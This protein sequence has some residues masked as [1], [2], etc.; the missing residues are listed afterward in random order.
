M[1]DEFNEARTRL[2]TRLEHFGFADLEL[3]R[4]LLNQATIV[5]STAKHEFFGVAVV[6]AMAAGAAPVLP[7]DLSYPE[8]IPSHVHTFTLYDDDSGLDELLTRFVSDRQL[9]EQV[10]TEVQASVERCSW[11]VVAPT[12]D[13]RLS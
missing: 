6:E 2:A 10:T 3:Y 7:N 9:V 1:P 8:L 11:E 13:Q 5:V 4:G 12:Y